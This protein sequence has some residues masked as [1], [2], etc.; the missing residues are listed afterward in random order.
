MRRR[1]LRAFLLI[2]AVLVAAIA[3][4]LAFGPRVRT[5]Q[6]RLAP[7]ARRAL[8]FAGVTLFDGDAARAR[9]DVL[10]RGATIAAV[11]PAGQAPP[12]ADALVIDGAGKTLLPGLVD[13][14]VHLFSAGQPAWSSY[15][16]DLPANAQAYLYAGV[17]S[18]L[19]A[20]V[21]GPSEED[22]LRKA[23]KGEVL[24]PHL[25]RAGPGL[26]APGGHPIPMVKALV[27]APLSTLAVREQPTAATPDQARAVAHRVAAAGFKLMKIFYDD[28][29]PGA[30]Q[31]SRAALAAAIAAARERGVRVVVHIGKSADMLDAAESGAAL[32]MHPPIQDRLS[33]PQIARLRA[34]G[35][36]FV[37]TMRTLAASDELAR[38]GGSP[39]EREVIEAKVLAAFA[40]RPAG[41]TLRGMGG[42][43]QRFLEAA[44]NMRENVRALIQAGV[45]FLVGTDA[46]L[47]G[48]LPGASMHEELLALRQL[49]VAPPALLRAATSAP[50]D[51]LDPGRSFGRVAPGQRADLLLV[52]GDAT[53]DLAALSRIE[54]V[55]LAGARLARTSVAAPG[56]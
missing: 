9:A 52:R 7:E 46:G 23:A 54:E 47:F 12:P 4:L 2:I 28:V 26:T 15:L 30:P 48:V 27:P 29:P 25:F 14:H 51:F 33:P 36:P 56:R 38:T 19:V 17:T 3:L 13:S 42:V 49:G 24:I 5:A 34:L 11:A 10:V 55:I 37:T 18:A 43:E 22:L 16:P 41:F 40:Q 53:V 45:P 31:L 6:V 35:V 1:A 44:A 32:L 8:F 50:A 20:Q 21:A 39:L